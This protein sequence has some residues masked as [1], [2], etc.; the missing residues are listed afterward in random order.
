MNRFNLPE[1]LKPLTAYSQFLLYKLVWDEVK[2]KHNKIPLN[3]RTLQVYP[4]GSNWQQDPRSTATYGEV[5]ALIPQLPEDY[6]VGYLFT[7]N[8]PF[9]FVD[10]DKCLQPDNT[11]S[12]IAMDIMGRLDGAAVEVS[13][14]GRGLHI[15]GTGFTP[16]HA[17]KNIPLNIE[18][19]TTGRFVALTGTNAIGAA[20]KDC[21]AGLS[22]LVNDYFPKKQADVSEWTTVA[23]PE[24]NGPEDDA[25]L[26]EQASKASSASSVFGGRATFNDL[27]IA[28][29]DALAAAYPDNEGTGRAYDGSSADAALAQHLAFWTGKNC[30]RIERIM[31]MSALVR[32]KWDREDYLIRTITRA[33][34]MQTAVYSTGSAGDNTLADSLGACKL[35]ASSDAQRS[36]GESIRAKKLA[37]AGADEETT[38]L[39]ASIPTAKTWIDNQEK[40]P[41]EIA[42]M[43][44]PVGQAADPLG[45]TS[46]GPKRVSGFQYLAADQQ[47]DHFKG[48]VYIQETHRIL[49]PKGSQ[50]KAEQFNATYG[51]YVFQLDES[52]DKVTRKA[53]EAFTE[54]QVI[55]YPKAESSCFRPDLQPGAIVDVDG[56]KLVN[57]YVPVTTRRQK[58]DI[59]PFTRHLALILPVGRDREIVLSYMAACVQHKGVKFQWTPLIQGTEGN[60]KTLLTRCVAFAIG[61]KYT[62]FPPAN[63]ISEKFNEWLFGKLFIGVEDIYVADH[64]KEVI[65]VLKP[66]ITNNKLAKRAMQ[67]SQVTA[68]SCANFMLNSNHKDALR[69]THSDRRFCIL[70]TAQQTAEDLA[71]DGMDGEYFPELYAW[72]NSDG[73][74]IVNEYLHT[75][76][77]PEELNPAGK[78]HRAPE[79]SSTGEAITSSMGGVEQEIIEAIEEN[80]L[81]F[82]GGWISSI[83]LDKLLQHTRLAAK[84]SHYKRREILRAL[85]YDWHPALSEGRANTPIALDDHKRPRLYIRKG[86]RD[87]RLTSAPD[88]ANA[89]IVA[90]SSQ[91]NSVAKEV[92][93]NACTNLRG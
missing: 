58:G 41:Q 20:A 17:S 53:W 81:G 91:E 32:E 46:T 67:Q 65:E 14:S 86:H 76:S 79:T 69:K 83:H 92:F 5:A 42:A 8:D 6:G 1:A 16:E 26:I 54:S 28:N 29:A 48:C 38:K 25:E 3:P 75:Y 21:T 74:A 77:I 35:R 22:R 55:R 47:L 73:Y 27:F 93:G 44:T 4:K 23:V 9:F 12:P 72:L 36:Y 19:Y 78:C 84:I 60:G 33:V 71:R 43:V 40:T 11:W 49:T 15:F 70:Y 90:Q 37:E 62:H 88:V 10:I 13:Q 63:E 80:R 18:M 64:K 51:G 2:Q 87:V 89:Y 39:L 61:D 59:T 85:G 56:N 52:G 68:D 24:Y 50:L 82:A 31:K 57:T 45:D 30:E 7:P 66:M 34:G